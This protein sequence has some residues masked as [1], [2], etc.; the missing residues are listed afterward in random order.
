MET[1]TSQSRYVRSS[2]AVLMF[3]VGFGFLLSAAPASSQTCNYPNWTQNTTYAVG[4]IVKYVPNG[5]YYKASHANP[6]PPDTLAYD[7]TISTYFW[8]PYT[9]TAATATAT[10]T[11]T[12]T[13]TATAPPRAT[14]TT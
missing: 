11:P 6:V 1:R 8:D 14:A 3:V 5:R 2:L 7:P 13:A 9:C 12:R 10:A 4:A